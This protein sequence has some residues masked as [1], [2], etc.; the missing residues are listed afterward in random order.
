MPAEQTKRTWRRYLRF[1]VRTMIVLVLVI[2][3]WLGWFV[4]S[5]RIQREA[6]A[7]IQA[8]GGSFFY[9]WQSKDGEYLDGTEPFA[10][11]SFVDRLGVDCFGYVAGVY[12]G[13]EHPNAVM[14][15]VGKLDRLETLYL[16]WTHVTDAGLANAMGLRKLKVLVLCDT[17]VTDAGLAHMQGL[18]SLRMLDLTNTAITDAGLV[19]LTGL[20]S[21]RELALENDDIT[22][23][24]LMHLKK[25]TGLES[26]YLRG[27]K[28]TDIGLEQLREMKWLRELCIDGT[29][30]SEVEAK[31]LQ[32]A[33]PMVEIFRQ[34]APEGKMGNAIGAIDRVRRIYHP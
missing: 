1:S 5:A 11:R 31:E 23:H 22:D 16:E 2:G 28:V 14:A 21:L 12:G 10:P 4:R 6:V 32:R 30:S 15:Q 33:L 34:S 27:T 19:H 9:N 20:S 25:L 8:A 7:A 29:S 3:G 26:L 18:V 17:D 24:G 13:Q